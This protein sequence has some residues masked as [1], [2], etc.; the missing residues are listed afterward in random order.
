MWA[1]NQVGI[2]LSFR[3]ASLCS[4]ATQ[5]QTRFLES[6]PRPIAGLKFSAQTIIYHSRL[7]N[8]RGLLY[9]TESDFKKIRVGREFN[10]CF[11]GKIVSGKVENHV[12]NFPTGRGQDFYSLVCA[13]EYYFLKSCF[14]GGSVMVLLFIW[15]VRLR[16]RFYC[17]CRHHG[18]TV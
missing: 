10:H 14:N 6:I 11:L 1:R 9:P 12:L 13:A 7:F 4:L 18:C 3:P 8:W 17:Y 2:G 15:T 5:F 16:E